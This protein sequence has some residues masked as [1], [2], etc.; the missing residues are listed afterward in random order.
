MTAGRQKIPRGRRRSGLRLQH[1]TGIG[2]CL[3][4]FRQNLATAM[5]SRAVI[6]QAKGILMAAQRRNADEA[7]QISEEIVHRAQ[8]TSTD[9]GEG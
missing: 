2:P 1:E 4:S 9:G 6:E 7:F 8:Q 3:G 5:Q